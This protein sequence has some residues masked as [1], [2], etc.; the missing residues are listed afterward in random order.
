METI[1]Q[2]KKSK[3][4]KSK[5]DNKLYSNIVIT[6]KVNIPMINIGSNLKNN[7]LKIL[8]NE[9]TGKCINEGFIQPNSINIVSYSNGI[10]E[11]NNIK[12]EV[13]F[14]CLACN[15]VEGQLI[16]CVAKNITKAGIRAEVVDEN[17]P[18][19]I[20]VARDHNYLNKSFSNVKEEQ[21]ITVR[22]IGQ[23]FE[24]NDVN[25]SVIADLVD[26]KTKNQKLSISEESDITNLDI[27]NI[28]DN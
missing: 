13:V 2:P 21:E 18:L 9:I 1:S 16:N 3:I 22:V 28:S 24:L 17:N 27:G 10:V 7:I 19:I 20:F 15:P 5:R 23:R 26:N 11:Q 6:K 4:K 25:I 8:E 14:E 12:F